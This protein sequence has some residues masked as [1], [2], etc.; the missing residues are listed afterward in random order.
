MNWGLS[1]GILGRGNTSLAPSHKALGPNTYLSASDF[2]KMLALAFVL[3]ALVFAIAALI[4]STKVTDIPVRALSFKLGGADRIAAYNPTPAAAPS[5]VAPPTLQAV[6]PDSWRA[7]PNVPA[8]VVPAPLAPVQPKPQ[9]KPAP[10]PVVKAP[11]VVKVEEAIVKQ[12]VAA[13]PA[14]A[15]TPQQYVREVGAPSQQA[16]AAAIANANRATGAADGAIGG[17]GSVTSVSEQTAQ[18]VRARYEQEI[19]AWI[20]QHKLYPASAGGREGRVVVRMRIDRGGN[21]RYYAIEQSSGLSIF[22][23]AALDMIRR[24]NP[25]PAVP[26]NYPASNLV[27]FLIPISFKAPQ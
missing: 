13:A 5:A 18:A 24:A 15:P 10:K 4:P 2:M 26:V 12:T 23:D 25:V 21:V 14:I 3:H 17:Q 16:V 7:T 1:Q 9:L 6:S 20:Q 22:D 27:E 19:S 8:P 11:R